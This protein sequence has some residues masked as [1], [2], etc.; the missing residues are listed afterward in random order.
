M[1]PFVE[2]RLVLIRD[3]IFVMVET[4]IRIA[5]RTE[6][7]KDVSLLGW[8]QLQLSQLVTIVLPL[9]S[10]IRPEQE[11]HAM[12]I[13]CLHILEEVV[14]APSSLLYMKLAEHL[15]LATLP[16]MGIH[17][18]ATLA[19]GTQ[20]LDRQ[21]SYARLLPWALLIEAITPSVWQAF[22]CH[23]FLQ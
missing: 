3:D 19:V 7:A 12:S 23:Q 11:A 17:G 1:I 14:K 15:T 16:S 5:F 2:K 8:G 13:A 9:A 10:Q 4:D 21:G 22:G 20:V 6:Q 18:I